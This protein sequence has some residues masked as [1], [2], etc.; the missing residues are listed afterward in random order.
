MQLLLTAFQLQ[1]VKAD[2]KLVSSWLQ[3]SE[4]RSEQFDTNDQDREDGSKIVPTPKLVCNFV[5]PNCMWHLILTLE[6]I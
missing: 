5:L 6:R 1:L 3:G 4:H 2:F